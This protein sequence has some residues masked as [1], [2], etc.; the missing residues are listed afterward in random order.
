MFIFLKGSA[1]FSRSLPGHMNMKLKNLFCFLVVAILCCQAVRAALTPFGNE[2]TYQGRLAEGSLVANGQYDLTFGLYDA[3]TAG[4]RLVTV[5]NLNVAV[6]NGLFTTQVNFGSGI[7]IGYALWIEIG[8]RT[9]GSSSAFAPL[10]P[11]QPITPTPNA[12][13]AALAA[14]VP[15][16][17]INAQKIF[18]GVAGNGNVLSYH[19]GNLVWTNPVAAAAGWRLSGN[20][21]TSAGANFVGTTDNQPLEVKVNGARALRIEPYGP[22]APSLIGGYFQNNAAGVAGAAIAGGG[23][24]ASWNEV[25]GNYGFIGAG[26]GGRAGPSSS[27]VGG[28]YN[29]APGQFSFVGGGLSN[30]NLGTN[31][32]LGGGTLNYIPLPAYGAVIG[33]GENNQAGTFASVSGG[34]GNHADGAYGTVAGGRINNALNTYATVG[35]GYNNVSSGLSATVG[36]GSDNVNSAEG[37]TIS[38]GL[39]NL[40]DAPGATVA[41]GVNNRARTFNAVVSGGANNTANANA[42]SVAGGSENQASGDQAAVGGGQANVASGNHAIVPG[43]M[44]NT[45]G[46]FTSFAAG[47]RATANHDGAFVW[48]DSS[49]AEFASTAENQFNV[50]ASGGVRLKTGGAGAHL[51]GPIHLFESGT[52]N[53]AR[54]VLAHSPAFSD[55]G[56]QYDDPPDRFN[57]VSDGI[58]VMTVDLGQM[59]VGV[60][61]SA[62]AESLDV[63]G[64]V[65]ASGDVRVGTDVSMNAGRSI[66]SSGRLH[67]Q[68]NEHLYLNPWAG[69]GPVVVGGGG[70]PG[71]LW[72]TGPTSATGIGMPNNFGPNPNFVGTTGNYIAFGHAGTSEDFIGYKN[73]TFYFK[74]SPGGA[75][76]CDPTVEISVLR[77]TGGCDLAEPF[78]MSSANIPSGAVVIIDDEN[79]GRLKLS[80][81]AY[82]RRVAGIVSGANGVKAG[83]TLHQEGTL[84]GGQNVALSGRVYVQADAASSGIKPGDLLTTS[85]SPGYAMKVTDHARAQG[86]ILGK[87]MTALQEGKGMV[88]VLVTLQ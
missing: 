28:A 63:E 39:G 38:G 61:T 85:D 56:L 76:T 43:G 30:T 88:L 71:E 47:Y 73:N 17:S 3:A 34:R 37:A 29:S 86:A 46:G 60:G 62:P 7:F 32:F 69:A 13:Y 51:D 74:D 65:R 44:L 36:G 79:P 64:N 48:A 75:D 9:N 35:G 21:G 19:D 27:V 80:Q 59:R 50:R 10:S 68:A 77:I 66:L 33:G 26:H 22:A 1:G 87:A 5:T 58:P 2:F 12:H 49:F 84:E 53:P 57:F 55:W 31:S 23:T 41:G 4:S 83:I 72:V 20:G 40:A 16:G 24:S 14:T 42:S 25:Q 52:G 82:D 67:V 81:Q 70:G 18:A 78:Q 6:T 15:N 8:V 45:A 54:M 11:R